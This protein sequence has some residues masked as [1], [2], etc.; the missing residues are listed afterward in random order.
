MAK[1]FCE[2]RIVIID[3]SLIGPGTVEEAAK[4]LRETVSERLEAGGRQAGADV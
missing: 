1:D 2:D 4:A 3:V